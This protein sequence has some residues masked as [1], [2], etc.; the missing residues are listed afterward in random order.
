MLDEYIYIHTHLYIH[1]VSISVPL[2]QVAT[3]TLKSHLST[4]LVKFSF[5]FNMSMQPIY[6]T[7]LNLVRKMSRKIFHLI[8]WIPIGKTEFRTWKC[9]CSFISMLQKKFEFS[10]FS[11]MREHFFLNLYIVMHTFLLKSIY[12]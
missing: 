10:Q 6:V 11:C 2:C 12:F 1:L 5:L 9:D 3:P 4:I 8:A 7:N